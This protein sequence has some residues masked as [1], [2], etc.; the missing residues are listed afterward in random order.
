MK[1]SPTPYIEQLDEAILNE[2]QRSSDD[3][4]KGFPLRPSSAGKCTRELAYE[5]NEYLGNEK[6]EK[7]R[8]EPASYRLLSLGHSVE[9]NLLKHV[10]LIKD[11]RVTYKQQVVEMFKVGDRIIE[12]SLD[13]VLISDK[14]KAVIDVKSKKDK[15]SK[16]FKTG[17]DEDD[18]YLANLKS[19]EQF[20]PS[21]FYIEKLA[22]FLK[23]IKDDPFL[24]ANFLQL[25]LY[26]NTKFLVDRGIDH[27]ALF[28]YNKNDSRLREIRFIPDKT[29][30][31]MIKTKFEVAADAATKNDPK[32]A[33][34]DYALGSMKCAFCPF[35]KECHG[36]ADTLKEWFKTFP[37]KQWPVDFHKIKIQK[38]QLGEFYKELLYSTEA[39]E[40]KELAE[41]EIL[42]IMDANEV[43]KIKFEDGIIYERVFLKSPYPRFE[44]RRGKL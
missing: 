23:E 37:K 18:A 41:Q 33:P 7:K 11:L 14:Y 32:L 43:N 12:G 9:W 3:D 39:S 28:Y 8:M 44:L 42:R 1:G 15:F 31:E 36:D 19:V 21:A 35:Q 16:A 34:K 10:D 26:A 2:I 6:Y 17:W 13:A 5:M 40:A 29:L 20:G 4:K 30:V 27:A 25:N 22:L 24:V 38:K